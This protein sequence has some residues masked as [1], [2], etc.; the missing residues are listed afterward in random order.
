MYATNYSTNEMMAVICAREIKNYDVVF[1]GVGLPQMAGLVAT[2]THAPDATVIYEGG[3][4]GPIT[5][6]MTW[7]ISDNPTTDNALMASQM[8][9]VF[10]D[11]QGGFV[12]KGVIGGAQIDKYGNLN[13]TVITNQG[14]ATYANPLVRLPGS[15]GANDIAS[16]CHETIIMM[17]LDRKKFVEKVDFIT[18]PGYLTGAGAREKAGLKGKGP[19]A[20]VTDKCVFRFDKKTKEMYLDTLYPGFTVE[21]ITA[22]IQWKLIVSENIKIAE[23]PLEEEINILRKF[24]P[25]GI[26]L[27]SRS[28]AND[29]SFEDYYKEMKSIYESISITF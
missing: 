13:T 3:G 12:N 19:V 26:I 10:A 18:S 2:R 16:S 7:T 24:D 27:G 17:R 9:Q 14:T 11:T 5:K 22:Q 6:R 25:N 21:D 29:Q 8:W 4:V 20:V 1:V 28:A 15:G 23:P